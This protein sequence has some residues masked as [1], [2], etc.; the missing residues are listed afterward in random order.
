[1]EMVMAELDTTYDTPTKKNL[2]PAEK[3]VDDNSPDSSLHDDPRTDKDASSS[4]P[5]SVG[6]A[7]KEAGAV[8]A[9]QSLSPKMKLMYGKDEKE[10]KKGYFGPLP[11]F[12]T[13][14]DFHAV[15]GMTPIMLASNPNFSGGV[16]AK[17]REYGDRCKLDVYINL[18]CQD[19]IG[20]DIVD[21]ALNAQEVCRRI[22]DLKQEYRDNGPR[23]KVDSPD[24]LFNKFL[25]FSTSLLDN[26]QE[27]PLQ[28][29][30]AYFAA[31][32]PELAERM[33]TDTF[34]MPHLTAL[35]TKAKQ[36]DALRYVR[37]YAAVSFKTLEVERD[38][39][40]KM[41]KQM[42][43]NNGPPRPQTYVTHVADTT[44][45]NAG[46]VYQYGLSQAESSIERYKGT[47]PTTPPMYIPVQAD[48]ETQ[49][50]PETG[51]QHPFDSSSNYLSKYPLGFRGCYA[52]GGTDHRSSKDCPLTHSGRFDK[53]SFF[54]EMWA[55]KPHT[56]NSKSH[57]PPSTGNY[58]SPSN[59]TSQQDAR[60]PGNIY[61]TRHDNYTRLTGND[62]NQGGNAPRGNFTR[63]TCNEQNNTS[64]LKQEPIDTR[65]H[66]TSNG[67]HYGPRSVNN[68]PLG[69]RIKLHMHHR[70]IRIRENTP[71]GLFSANL[72]GHS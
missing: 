66:S 5:V 40:S 8:L 28:L 14:S 44:S 6:A 53:Q 4:D 47:A 55:H 54:R 19:Y 42:N 65:L 10:Y 2:F 24:E 46:Q 71:Y 61:N 9:M 31:L 60:S 22:G 3:E 56:K 36:L 62:Y 50:N 35:T 30:S 25:Q 58:Y 27:C 37:R 16:R 12:N 64:I 41:L 59:G 15:F 45:N 38:R 1:M 67:N 7:T 68:N 23:N 69:C 63:P 51:L 26:A 21:A 48:V 32:T 72:F 33:T 29:C 34:R 11:F 18:C 52:C 13:Q 70:W 57:N 39:M 17:L 20:D 49:F 43:R